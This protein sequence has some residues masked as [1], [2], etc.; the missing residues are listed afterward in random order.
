MR[1]FELLKEDPFTVQDIERKTLRNLE[2]GSAPS[3]QYLGGGHYSHA[4][5]TK[6]NP[7]DVVKGTSGNASIEDGYEGFIRALAADEEMRD[8]IYMPRI[9]SA[10]V[11]RST[12]NPNKKRLL[13]RLERLYNLGDLSEREAY[14]MLV[15]LI[16]RENA[17]SYYAMLLSF[18][19]QQTKMKTN[20]PYVLKEFLSDYSYKNTD[21]PILDEEFIK[22]F[23]WVKKVAREES[24]QMDLH[25]ENWMFRRT[26]Y[27]PQLVMM[28][29]LAWRKSR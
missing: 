20:W 5:T 26:P 22:A 8:N 12:K 24:W 21:Y 15:K 1:L 3:S 10:K 11:I 6:D 14:D 27:G 13:V 4:F 17:R 18:D 23:E 2:R 25:S 7:H 28:D 19:M 29:P 9:R 16:G